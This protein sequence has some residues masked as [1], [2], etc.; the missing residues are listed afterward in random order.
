MLQYTLC[1]YTFS[2]LLFLFSSDKY[3]EVE[4]L[5]DSS[6]FNFFRKL[7]TVFYSG[8]TNLHFQQQY[9]RVPC[10]AHP[11]QY[12]LFLVFLDNRQSDSCEVIAHCGFDLHF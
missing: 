10:S 12:L 3:P 5:D 11:H 1:V 2:E 9:T 7:H 4:L 8:C 6:I